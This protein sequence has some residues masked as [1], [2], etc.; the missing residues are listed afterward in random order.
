VVLQREQG[1]GSWHR[2]T[3][4]VLA[5]DGTYSFTRA[6]RLP[7]EVSLRVVARGP[8]RGAVASE[9]V[10][11]VVVAPQNPKLTIH[12]SAARSA[13]GQP[14]TISGV[15]TG[16]DA[17]PVTLLARVPG[18]GF[19]EV[20]HATTDAGGAYAFSQAPQSSTTYV[21]ASGRVRSS[22]LFHAV[23]YALTAGASPVTPAAGET[24]TFSGSV[25]PAPA[26]QAV[27]LQR[28]DAS[29]LGW[30]TVNAATVAPDGSYSLNHLAAGVQSAVF[31]V[32]VPRGERLA[33]ASSPPFSLPV[34]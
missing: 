9:P 19:Q 21:V 32:R 5:L 2:V 4:G 26:G 31:R 28:L 14:L 12:A 1:E 34:S 13:Y 7:G 33:A 11:F 15:L 8:G 18:S 10:S 27:Y 22:P 16:A 17:A 20:A 29:G 25:A 23:S 24:V 6:F 3:T 30:R